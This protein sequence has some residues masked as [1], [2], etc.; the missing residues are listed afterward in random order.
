MRILTTNAV[1]TS[2]I[3]TLA[4]TPGYVFN[5]ALKDT[6]RSR[7]GRT[8]SKDDQTVTFDLTVATAI[9]YFVLMDHNLTS[10]AVV[11][12][13][14]HSSDVWTDPD[15]DETI[16]IGTVLTHNF[17]AAETYRYWRLTIDDPTN[18]NDYIQFSTVYLG[19]YIQMPYMGKDQSLKKISTSS[20]QD[21]NSGQTSGDKGYFYKSGTINFKYLS[22]TERLTYE[23]AFELIDKYIPFIS[24][25]WESSLTLEPPLYTTLTTDFDFQRADNTGAYWNLT[26]AIKETF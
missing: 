20:V 6:W 7:K 8:L 9:T 21:S 14:G 5:V 19:G 23:A 13:Q 16:T 4:E 18:A 11:H 15:V 1:L 3:T 10:A 25:I 22:N 2:T 26:F 17:S 24:I 12:L